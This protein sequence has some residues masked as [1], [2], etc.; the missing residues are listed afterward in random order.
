MDRARARLEVRGDVQ[1]VGF[2]PFVTRLARELSLGGWVKNTRRGVVLEVE[3]PGGALDAFSRRLLEDLPAPGLVT[4][5][6]RE[7]VASRGDATFEI[8]P[9][10][11]GG[12]A[13]RVTP[14]LATCP[15]CVAELTAP[16]DRRHR[17]PFVSCARCGPRYTIVTAAP[18]DR[19]RTTMA[20]F[21]MCEACAREYADPSDR[22]HHAQTNACPAC[23]PEV[24]L[25]SRR[26]EEVA[27]G[28]RAMREAAAAIGS[29]ACVAVKGIGGF[30]LVVDAT[31]ERAVASLRRRKGRETKPFA[32]MVASLGEAEALCVLAEAERSALA[33]HAAPIVLLRRRAGAGIA[34]GVAPETRT[35]GL[36][37]AYTPLHHVLCRDVGAPIV[38]TSGNVDG[39]PL[40]TRDDEALERLSGI[41][42]LFL[43]HDRAIARPADD[44]VVRVIARRSVT[45]RRARGLAPRPVGRADLAEGA[46][47]VGGHLKAAVAIA[48]T[49]EILLGP[50]VGDLG[51]ARARARHARVAEDLLSL[52]GVSAAEVARDLHPDYGSH[53]L[54]ASRAPTAPHDVQHHEAHL[55]ACLADNAAPLPCLGVVW[56]G[57]GL[58]PD[59]TLWGGE[60]LSAT[61]SGVSRFAH[62]R[63]FP[64]PGGERAA[65]D[66]RRAAIGL[67][68]ERHGDAAFTIDGAATHAALSSAELR[69]LRALLGS[70]AALPRTSSAGRLFDAAAS[71]LGLSHTSGHEGAAAVRLEEAAEGRVEPGYTI[72]LDADAESPIVLD[73]APLLDAM[74]EDVRRGV[75]VAR[76]A[77]RFHGALVESIVACAAR[78]SVERVALSGGCFQN[79]LLSEATT[80]ALVRAGHVPLTHREIPPN[81]GGL[82]AGQL[83]WLAHFSG[84]GRRAM[85]APCA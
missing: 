16:T 21:T 49:G 9:S 72:A 10:D 14:D 5:L 22:R 66:G 77:A 69:A 51:G 64:L 44:S 15:E 75:P 33:S 48:V 65:R 31:S 71:I 67:L 2:R 13:A 29:G 8:H 76:C 63:T 42:D 34:D 57:A 50:H 55:F 37:L 58:G 43:T 62:L 41:A 74:M 3:G 6:T 47:A 61:E 81:D 36:M 83:A 11:G 73:W 54:A 23:G 56:D 46:L 27:R 26:G 60:L 35:L 12:G 17:Y 7:P 80:A 78:A 19:A 24:R 52:F 1:G 68:F 30:H 40:C 18:Y 45:L 39:E 82:A 70:R 38:A 53:E 20:P 84:A 32:A 79:A 28:D 4:S 85:S 25:L 59:G